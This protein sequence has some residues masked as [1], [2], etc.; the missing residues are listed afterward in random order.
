MIV[1]LVLNFAM[2]F[3]KGKLSNES[4]LEVL[5]TKIEPIRQGKNVVRVKVRN[6]TNH[7]RAFG[8]GIY[9]R[10]PDHGKNGVG[11]GTT[12]FETIKSKETKWAQFAFKI[13]GPITDTTWMRLRFYDPGIAEGFDREKWGNDQ[14]YKSWLKEIKYTSS[15]LEH[16]K[17]N[18]EMPQPVIDSDLKEVTK[19]FDKFQSY[20]K[21]NKYEKAWELFTSDCQGAEFHGRFESFKKPME[22]VMPHRL[23]CWERD[24][25]LRLKAKDA[26]NRNG[27]IVLNA[28]SED[29]S[30]NI[31]LV[32]TEDGW[33]IDWISGYKSRLVVWANW[34]ETLLP[35]L[36]KR[37]TEHF[38]I[39]YYKDSTAEKE[40][41]Q[42]S[43]QKE[44]GFEDICSFLGKN[45]D[46]KIR[47][48]L[49]DDMETKQWETGHQGMGWAFGK[50]IVEVYSQ[51]AKLDPYHE[52]VHVI[53][54][55]QGSP[56]ALFTEG[57]AVYMSE[58]LGAYALESLS[59]GKS[60]IY[61][62]TTA[63]KKQNKLIPLKELITYTDIGSEE[64]K[65]AVAYPEAA[66]FVKYLV[67]EYGKR[68]FLKAYKYLKNSSDEKIYK[69]NSK[70]LAKMYGSSLEELITQWEA[71][72]QTNR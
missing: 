63:L 70:K 8:T 46:V 21:K 67:D 22:K 37:S 66:S 15:K 56:P 12:F 33:K 44:K 50:T 59:G 2:P 60:S 7:D 6:T 64:T 65:P 19:V 48:V 18:S 42:L 47:I 25:F 31:D 17:P 23:F 13:Q 24:E 58:K 68:K 49:F 9:T 61:E 57:F 32:K 14:G 40:I 71:A 16:Y 54:S 43:Q 28:K 5:D 1:C 72:L 11:W 62:R 36:E 29:D 27:T 3:S 34:E 41:E 4:D 52:A 53:M 30:W 39:Y 69:Q 51:D 20:V 55:D 26:Y 38:D 10:S 35:K 45:V